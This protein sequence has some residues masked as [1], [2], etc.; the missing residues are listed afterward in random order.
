VPLEPRVPHT[1]EIGS[2]TIR[3]LVVDDHVLV[4]Q[5]VR[6]LLED[7]PDVEIVDEAGSAAEA[8]QK[9]LQHRPDVVLMDIGMPGLSA[10]EAA[11]VIRKNCPDTRLLFLTMYEDEEYVLQCL[12]AGGAGYVVKDTSAQQLVGALREVHRGGRYVSPQVFGKL[13]ENFQSRNQGTSVQPRGSLL[14]PREREVLKL[15]AEG[16]PVKAVAGI[17]GLSAK[18]VEVHKFNLMRKLE[19]HNKAQ[20]VTYAIRKKIVK[21]PLGA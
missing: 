19:L 21:V 18:T 15:L 11:R 6:R 5:G 4:R 2:A 9:A 16:N 13:V 7:E 8:V 1:M 3:C 20:L 10:F 12:E 17:L 14:T